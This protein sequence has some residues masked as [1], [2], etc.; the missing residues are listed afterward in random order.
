MTL[1][2]KPKEFGER[3]TVHNVKYWAASSEDLS[4]DKSREKV[5]PPLS[6]KKRTKQNSCFVPFIWQIVPQID[7][8]QT[9]SLFCGCGEFVSISITHKPK[10]FV[11]QKNLKKKLKCYKKLYFKK[12]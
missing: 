2:D 1:K 6:G 9:D 4:R 12:K 10:M 7:G 5:V 8:T 3:S 11:G